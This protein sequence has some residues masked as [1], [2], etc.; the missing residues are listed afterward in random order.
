MGV[1]VL[2]GPADQQQPAAG[3][4]TG[5]REGGAERGVEVGLGQ[6]VAAPRPALLD[7]EPEP[8]L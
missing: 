3:V 1:G 8:R 7:R 6:G 5:R 4:L 2:A